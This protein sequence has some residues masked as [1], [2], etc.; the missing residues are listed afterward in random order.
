MAYYENVTVKV[1]KNLLLDNLCDNCLYFYQCKNYIELNT[2]DDWTF[3][4]PED[5]REPLRIWKRKK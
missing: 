2:C 5:G 1:I 4:P 3:Q